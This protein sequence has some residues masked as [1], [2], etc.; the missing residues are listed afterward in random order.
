MAL[1]FPWSRAGGAEA[2]GRGSLERRQRLVLAKAELS[3]T[4]QQKGR[5]EGRCPPAWHANPRERGLRASPSLG[6]CPN[7]W[8]P[9]SRFYGMSAIGPMLSARNPP[10]S[11]SGVWA[12]LMSEGVAR[13]LP[14]LG[15]RAKGLLA[16]SSASTRVRFTCP[17]LAEQ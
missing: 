6:R 10:R 3:G 4:F 17:A 5:K 16:H 12:R 1:S 15:Q 14:F 8:T 13:E 11:A 9:L 2:R 7:V